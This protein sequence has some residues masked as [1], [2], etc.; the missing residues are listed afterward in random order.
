[1][2]DGRKKRSRRLP[3]SEFVVHL[4]SHS[5]VMNRYLLSILVY[6]LSQLSARAQCTVNA[7]IQS[8]PSCG[9]CNGVVEFTFTGTPPFALNVNGILS[10]STTG[11]PVLLSNL[12]PGQYYFSATDISQQCTGSMM[13]FVL[14]PS[15]NPIALQINTVPP[16]CS[17]CNDGS[18]TVNVSGGSAPYVYFWSNGSTTPSISGLT[19]GTY[20]VCVMD[21]NGC[22]MCDS[23]LLQPSNAAAWLS[24]R[25]YWDVDGDSSYSASDVPLKG[26]AVRLASRQ[27]ISMSNDSG[28]F[29]VADTLGPD[30]VQFIGNGR[31]SLSSGPS[32]Y[33]LNVGPGLTG[34]LDFALAPDSLYSE[35]ECFS[36]SPLPRCNQQALFYTSVSNQGTQ[37]DSGTVSLQFDPQ[38]TFVSATPPGQ[39]NGNQI[40]FSYG[41]LAPGATQ[42]YTLEFQLPGAGSQL[43]LLTQAQVLSANGT[44][45]DSSSTLNIVPVICAWDPNDKSVFPQGTGP[46]NV[47]PVG[48]KL[49]YLVR[50]QNTGNDTA[51]NV[52]ILDTLDSGIDPASVYVISSSHP[53]W[54]QQLS[55]GVMRYSFNNILLPDSNVNEPAS[56]GYILFS[57]NGLAANPDPTVVFNRAYIYFDENPPI[58][59]NQ[60]KTT[61]SNQ[62]QAVQ[63]LQA[64]EEGSIRVWPHPVQ[65]EARLAWDGEEQLSY[66]LRIMDIQGRSTFEKTVNGAHTIIS[67]SDWPDGLY[68]AEVSAPGHTSVYRT[69][70]LVQKR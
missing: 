43:S 69:R 61:F 41:G 68:L 12:C 30:T 50:F 22:Q 3:V 2:G 29:V 57:V 24:G 55:G 20:T 66:R 47:V 70:L 17:T 39:V 32:E 23:F 65:S 8:M 60:V 48:T 5:T 49:R 34:G 28:L 33:A 54:I 38:M 31:F 45:T 44:I 59:T 46:D 15:S 63:E 7:S 19:A 36:W 37:V 53:C 64:V 1:M 11:A 67:M 4:F 10:G 40:T 27:L 14:P 6:F 58:V 13:F 18:A 62:I 9:L 51:F 25:V 56:H 35:V 42:T 16:G 21:A 26:Q 52:V